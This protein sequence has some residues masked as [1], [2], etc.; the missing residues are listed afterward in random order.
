MQPRSN[1][2][3]A[4]YRIGV[5]PGIVYASLRHHDDFEGETIQETTLIHPKGRDVN[6]EN[7]KNKEISDNDSP[8][9]VKNEV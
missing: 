3:P 9:K 4:A 5:V 6:S 7:I 8:K 1:F 2:R